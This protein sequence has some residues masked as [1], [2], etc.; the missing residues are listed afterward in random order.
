MSYTIGTK[1]DLHTMVWTALWQVGTPILIYQ[2]L[3]SKAYLDH[4]GVAKPEDETITTTDHYTREV[5]NWRKISYVYAGLW[6]P[7]FLLGLIS[8]SEFMETYTY[9]YIKHM[10][11]NFYIPIYAYGMYQVFDAAVFEGGW[12][13]VTKVI[14][15]WVSS[16]FTFSNQD[17]SG[18]L[19]MGYLT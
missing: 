12:Q 16:T 14:L 9:L 5:Y 19:T 3:E 4:Y 11:S 10:I 8:L 1:G 2:V 17:S 13:G 6:G 7:M 15:F 18:A